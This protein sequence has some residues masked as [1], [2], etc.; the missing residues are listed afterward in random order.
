MAGGKLKINRIMRRKFKKLKKGALK[1]V[2]VDL[3]T[4]VMDDWEPINGRKAVVK[5]KVYLQKGMSKKVK[6]EQVG[7]QG[8]IFATLMEPDTPDKQGDS[9][10]KEEI[11]KACYKFNIEK[12]LV[13]RI[14][15][16]HSEKVLDDVQIVESSILKAKDSE[17]YPGVKVGSWV[18][19]L[20]CDTDSDTWAAVKKGRLNG[21]SF[22]GIGQDD[23][24]Q[25]DTEE[26]T[27]AVNELKNIVKGIGDGDQKKKI[28]ER[29]AEIEKQ[30]PGNEDSVNEDLQEVVKAFKEVARE[31][32]KVVSKAI[33]SDEGDEPDRD[34]R[35]NGEKIILKGKKR[36][37]YKALGNLDTG[38]NMNIF[39]DN[40]GNQFIDATLE[41][42]EDDT[43]SDISVV[44]LGSDNKVDKGLIEDIILNNTADGIPDEQEAANLDLEVDPQELDAHFSLKETTAEDYRKSHGVEEFGAYVERKIGKNI[45]KGIKRLLYRGDRTSVTK[46]LKGFNG[47]VKVATSNDDITEIQGNTILLRIVNALRTFSQDALTEINMGGVIYLNSHDEISLW[48]FLKDRQTSL[49]D[50]LLEK[51]GKLHIKSIPVKVRYM[52]TDY[53]V[54][55]LPK[56]I[57]CGYVR[58]AKLK[59]EHHGEDHKY[60]WY[61]RLRAGMNYITGGLIKVFHTGANLAPY[62]S[63]VDIDGTGTV[64]DILT[65]LYQYNDDNGDAEGTTT[66]KW[67]ICAT[68]GGTYSAISG[69]TSAQYTPV[70]DDATKYVKFGVT[71]KNAAGIAGAEVLSDAQLISA[72]E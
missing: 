56:F 66:Y 14:D 44:P 49:G 20:K 24:S 62:A 19:T 10:S 4:I 45:M 34:I 35:I 32:K 69:A 52:P 38:D 40:L 3:V 65:G 36:E 27:K 54:I 59:V 47:L 37:L 15:K 13:N 48:S 21:I 61:P 63:D 25:V 11:R 29:I 55:G 26:L 28:E 68:A 30:I 17:H 70:S 51:D 18:Q 46:S 71:V 72:A 60:H 16:N 50:M 5:G 9:Y 6:S 57:V 8:L 58:D 41:I 23:N 12:G 39:A 53:F 33:K 67:Y 7:D 31:M 64:G 22:S 43:L 2:D 1:N 42:V